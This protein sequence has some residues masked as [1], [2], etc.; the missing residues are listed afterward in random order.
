MRWPRAT[1]RTANPLVVAEPRIALFAKAPVLGEVKTR[2]ARDIG[3][4]AALE[5]YRTLLERAATE[6]GGFDGRE[7]WTAG[8]ARAFSEIP[9]LDDWP[10]YEQTGRNLGER[11]SNAFEHGVDIL[12][13]ADIPGLDTA[14]LQAA[15]N[16]LATNDVVLGPAED[17]GY[18]LIGMTAYHPHVFNDID[19]STAQVLDQ[20]LDRCR[21]KNL[22]VALLGTLWDV[23]TLA[24]YERANRVGLL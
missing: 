24:D 3:D 15:A 17:G 6:V 18:C 5:V 21:K 19:W 4:L 8:D 2:L 14:Y 13:G 11:M 23:D 20:T 22:T 16:A 12:I 7:L 9:A 10:R 1:T